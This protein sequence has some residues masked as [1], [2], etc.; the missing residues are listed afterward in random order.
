[1]SGVEKG[2]WG[3]QG[4]WQRYLDGCH[5]FDEIIT[6]QNLTDGEI[7]ERLKSLSLTLPQGDMALLYK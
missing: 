4:D 3:S 5:S 7:I 1:V 2:A 6:E